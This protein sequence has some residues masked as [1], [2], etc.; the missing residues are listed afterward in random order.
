MYYLMVV[1]IY[2]NLQKQFT[3]T[4][5]LTLPMRMKGVKVSAQQRMFDHLPVGSG[6]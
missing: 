2:D 4:T 5:R 3:L 6:Q 1:V